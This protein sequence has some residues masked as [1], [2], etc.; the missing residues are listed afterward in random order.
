MKGKMGGVMALAMVAILAISGMFWGNGL[1]HRNFPDARDPMTNQISEKGRVPFA[2]LMYF[3]FGFNLTTGESEGGIGSSHWNTDYGTHN[4]KV[5]VTDEPEYGFYSSDDPQVIA[6]QLRDMKLAGIDT[7]LASWHGTGDTNLDGFFDQPSREG[8]PGKD[9]PEKKAM[10]RAIKMMLDYIRNNN[11]RFKVAILVEPYMANGKTAESLTLDDKNHILNLLWDEIYEP[12]SELMFE[13]EGK[14]LL[15]PWAGVDLKE[16][17]DPR[18][19]VRNWASTEYVDWKDV[20]HLDWNWYPNPS[21][22]PHMLSDDGVF[23]VFPRYDESWMTAFGKVLRD[24]D[25]NPREP[26]TVDPFLTEGVYEQIWQAAVDRRDEVNLLVLYSWNELEEHA[27]IEPD[28]GHSPVSYRRT[29]IE[30]TGS[31]YRKFLAGEDIVSNANAWAQPRELTHFIGTLS[32]SELGLPVDVSL[33]IFLSHRLEEAKNL[34]EGHIGRTYATDELPPA[35]KNI[36]L[37]LASNIY[38]YILMNK[39]NPVTQVGEFNFQIN[40][41]SVFTDALKVDLAPFRKRRGMTVLYP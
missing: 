29:L 2:A 4:Q 36:Q 26:R 14:P 11:E 27:A 33:D 13:W 8:E 21:L 17:S 5:G 39:R 10:H 35:V 19:T 1:H 20:G 38:N 25:G 40:D 31:Y 32:E 18:F 30:K 7:I 24:E 9:D 6:Q 16:P 28:K 41:D 12:Y 34:V 37:R 3:W 23:V 22:A 15:I